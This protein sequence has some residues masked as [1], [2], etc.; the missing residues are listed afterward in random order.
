MPKKPSSGYNLY[1]AERL[2]IL[3]EKNPTKAV[4]EFFKII[5]AEWTGMK[6]SAKEKYNQGYE[7][8]LEAYKEK[9]KEFKQLGYYTPNKADIGR[10]SVS[11]R[12][13]SKGKDTKKGKGK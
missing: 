13:T 11:R 10:K 9:V 4:T 1:I 3:K 6:K 2:P 7:K 12:S 8:E 5:A